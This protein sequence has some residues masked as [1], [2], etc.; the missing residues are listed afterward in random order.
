MR[1]TQT[2]LTSRVL[3]TPALTELGNPVPGVARRLAQRQVR[4]DTDPVASATG[5]IAIMLSCSRP[6]SSPDV[7][8]MRT[9]A[10]QVCQRAGPPGVG[11]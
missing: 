5:I 9:P 8:E 1:R 10:G 6:R 7:R 11:W 3:E 4:P 2:Q